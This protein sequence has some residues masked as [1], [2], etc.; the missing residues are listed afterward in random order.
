ARTPL[1]DGRPRRVGVGGGGGLRAGGGG[2]A[3]SGGE[4]WQGS[5]R[6]PHPAAPLR[7]HA[8]AG[9]SR[10][11]LCDGAPLR[12]AGPAAVD[13]R[14][15]RG[16]LRPATQGVAHGGAP[17]AAGRGAGGTLPGAGR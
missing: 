3:V 11:A 2:A 1:G 15:G 7:H 9:I 5:Q 10:T 4:G 17:G 16:L 12:Q 14:N 13:E 6:R 8:A